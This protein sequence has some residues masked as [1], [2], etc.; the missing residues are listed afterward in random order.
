MDRIHTY[1]V[2][3]VVAEPSDNGCEAVRNITFANVTARSYGLPEFVGT[4]DCPLENFT[5]TGC[6]FIRSDAPEVR[7]PWL[8]EPEAWTRGKPPS[9]VK[10]GF[11]NGRGSDHVDSANPF[12]NCKGFT[13][14]ACTFDDL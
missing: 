5:F 7:P 8:K 14:N 1:P 11:L 13:F 3:V 2:S 9:V 12:H 4:R 6:R 10:L